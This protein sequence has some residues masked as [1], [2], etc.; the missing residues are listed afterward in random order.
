MTIENGRQTPHSFKTK[1]N[2]MNLSFQHQVI[3][4]AAI[5]MKAVGNLNK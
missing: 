1:T 3:N 4:P 2:I 5:L